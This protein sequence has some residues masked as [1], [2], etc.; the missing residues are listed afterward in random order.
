MKG[1]LVW[2]DRVVVLRNERDEWELPGGRLEAGDATPQAALRREFLEELGI[3]VEVGTLVDSWI[4]D[5]AGK[6][7]FIVTYAV[8]GR[9]PAMLE[10]SDEHTGV[11]L[12][13]RHELEKAPIPPGYVRSI[14]LALAD[15][16][17]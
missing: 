17:G 6:R 14:D 12:L 10:H 2:D 5:V 7:V 13:A 11:A 8:S 1:V 15:E 9:R 16:L 4:Y 3:E